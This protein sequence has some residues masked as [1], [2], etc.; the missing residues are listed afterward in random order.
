MARRIQAFILIL[1]SLAGAYYLAVRLG[2]MEV[3]PFLIKDESGKLM[4]KALSAYRNGEYEIASVAFRQYL[5]DEPQ[6]VEAWYGLALSLGRQEKLDQA[7]EA[8]E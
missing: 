1:I 6:D 8:E 7:L 5:V 3:P 2:W 4:S